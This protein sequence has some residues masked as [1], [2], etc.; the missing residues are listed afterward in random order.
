MKGIWGTDLYE[1]GLAQLQA[2]G[3]GVW[4]KGEGKRIG[5]KSHSFCRNGKAGFRKGRDTIRP[6]T[7]YKCCC[8]ISPAAIVT[9]MGGDEKVCNVSTLTSH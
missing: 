8:M 4:A 3:G 9:V 1:S 2:V 7:S 5:F 6:L